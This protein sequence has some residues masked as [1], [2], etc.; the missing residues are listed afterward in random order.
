MLGCALT[1]PKTWTYYFW[2]TGLAAIAAPGVAGCSLQRGKWARKLLVKSALQFHIF[3][4]QSSN[5]IADT[6][7]KTGL[8][9]GESRFRT[10]FGRLLGLRAMAFKQKSWFLGIV[11]NPVRSARKPLVTSADH[12]YNEYITWCMF[13]N[14]H[15][16]PA[17][18]HSHH[19][20]AISHSGISDDITEHFTS[21][22]F[23]CSGCCSLLAWK[24]R[25]NFRNLED[26]QWLNVCI[27]EAEVRHNVE[28]T[29]TTINYLCK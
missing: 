20:S 9:L 25:I 8:D 11:L 16:S 22:K 29:K 24:K 19:F 26:I 17:Q 15:F 27:C 1:R 23:A 4:N 21:L 13:M 14:A 3:V 28:W 7:C 5:H 12:L 10:S 2:I 6:M 18:H